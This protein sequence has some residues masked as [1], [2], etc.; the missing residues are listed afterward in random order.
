MEKVKE[1]IM[2]RYER[3]AEAMSILLF[4]MRTE[5][6]SNE[7]TILSYADQYGD[8]KEISQTYIDDILAA[9]IHQKQIK[10]LLKVSVLAGIT[11]VPSAYV[12]NKK[13][14]YQY[15]S[16]VYNHAYLLDEYIYDQFL[17]DHPEFHNVHI[18]PECGSDNVQVRVWVRPNQNHKFVD[19]IKN[20][21]GFCDDC[22]QHV[23]VDITE[24]NVRHEVI[25]YQ[26]IGVHVSSELHPAILD[27]KMIY[28]LLDADAMLRDD[29]IKGNWKL[30]T[31]WTPDI[32][33][34]VKMFESDPRI[35]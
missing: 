22:L 4:D 6:M 9:D 7:R 10:L 18:C 15:S 31:I 2:T 1:Y 34:P 20:Q 17:R 12:L 19:E 16:E 33:D 25:G 8:T 13:G 29:T 24:M 28:N 27:D 26:V 11:Q 21:P 35:V 32:L 3:F 14:E 30:K 5:D 23:H